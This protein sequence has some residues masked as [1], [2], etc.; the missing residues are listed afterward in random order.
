MWR[1]INVDFNHSLHIINKHTY[2]QTKLNL[3][4]HHNDN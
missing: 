4:L 2:T 3:E 1:I